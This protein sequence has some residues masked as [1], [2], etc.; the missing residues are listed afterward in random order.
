MQNWH[1][2]QKTDPRNTPCMGWWVGGCQAMTDGNCKVNLELLTWPETPPRTRV[3]TPSRVWEK[4]FPP[5]SSLSRRKTTLL[6]HNWE[7]CQ[8]EHVKGQRKGCRIQANQCRTHYARL[9]LNDSKSGNAKIKILK[10]PTW[11]KKM[12]CRNRHQKLKRCHCP[13]DCQ[14]DLVTSRSESKVSFT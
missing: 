6:T 5:L 3:H 1:L 14:T 4:R 11:N 13:C 7:P 2:I 9:K 8:A 12:S 10:C